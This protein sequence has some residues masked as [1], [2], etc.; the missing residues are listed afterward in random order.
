MSDR[1]VHT[2]MTSTFEEKKGET[3]GL[4]FY[5]ILCRTEMYRAH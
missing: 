1:T 5:E 4:I 3:C 2:S